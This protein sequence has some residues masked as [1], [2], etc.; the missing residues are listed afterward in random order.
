MAQF[1]KGFIIMAA[2]IVVACPRCA[3]VQ[4]LYSLQPSS[5]AYMDSAQSS[6][7][8]LAALIEAGAEAT[9]RK[10]FASANVTEGHG[11]VLYMVY[12]DSNF[13]KTRLDWI[14]QTW[15]AQLP[16]NS[17]MVIGD[18]APKE[19]MAV[20]VH[21]TSCPAHSHWEGACCKYAEAV[22]LAQKM[23]KKDR[24]F[25]WAYFVDDDA[26]VRTSAL[27]HAL[28]SQ[29][30]EGEHGVLF[31]N[32]GCAA[33][34]K[35]HGMCCGGG[36]A[37]SFNALT[38]AV[39]DSP[40]NFLQKQMNYCSDCE[41]WADIALTQ[42]YKEQGTEMKPLA[43]LNG[44]KLSKSNFDKSLQVGQPEPLMYHYI[45]SWNQMDMLHRLFHPTPG[46]ATA[47]ADAD[48]QTRRCVEYRG[49]K[50]CAVSATAAD[51]PWNP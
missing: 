19:P 23:M 4:P 35:C 16:S 40:E 5:L 14:L 44:W 30:P 10:Y 17:L 2:L 36:Y 28:D 50:Q 18:A 8:E 27:E 42:V 13:Y 11:K 26:Y 9:A 20:N 22:I 25:K 1:D 39:G 15:V 34:G 47:S 41:R 33:H 29:Q 31:S 7:L 21:S 32:L 46:Q 38:E 24:T 45:G 37:A 43:G 3:A 6:Y 49:N 12:S 51:S 48:T